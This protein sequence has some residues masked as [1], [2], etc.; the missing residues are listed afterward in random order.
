M[1]NGDDDFRQV[2]PLCV[3]KL[4]IIGLQFPDLFR[5]KRHWRM[6]IIMQIRSNVLTMWTVK[7]SFLGSPCL[8]KF[9]VW[10]KR[11]SW[12]TRALQRWWIWSVTDLHRSP[13]WSTQRAYENSSGCT[14]HFQM[15]EGKF[16]RSISNRHIFIARQHSASIHGV[17]FFRHASGQTDRRTNK[18]WNRHRLA[19]HNTSHTCRAKQKATR[20]TL[21][22]NF[23][24][25]RFPDRLAG[26]QE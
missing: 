21:T 26:F 2:A 3:I 5:T 6:P 7:C 13:Y 20:T 23:T 1:K 11:F 24:V 16:L 12:Q 19:D 8:W 14:G 22:K 17:W 25:M 15:S 4:M 9:K 10:W 18:Q